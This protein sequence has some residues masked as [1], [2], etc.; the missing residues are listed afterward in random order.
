MELK[1]DA[2]SALIIVDVQKDF[3]PG[4]ALPVPKGAEV[5]PI[6]NRYI[7]RFKRVGGPVYATRD[8]HP[9]DHVSFKSQGGI[10]PAHCVKG[11]DGAEFHPALK[12]PRNTRIVSKATERNQ[13]AYSGFQG[14]DLQQDLK[15]KDVETA[16]VGGLATDY[17][18]KSTVLDA[19]GFGFKAVLL[20][21]AVRGVNLKPDDSEK[22]IEEMVKKGAKEA[23]LSDLSLSESSIPS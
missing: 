13:E 7:E 5:V 20:K 11:T 6:L 15:K 10:W 16:F 8:L 3:C 1:T 12:L 4:G 22:A 2:R 17:C 23:F 19:L 18:V 9:P 14:T 21:D